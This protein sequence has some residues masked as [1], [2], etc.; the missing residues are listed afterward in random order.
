M[1]FTLLQSHLETI[2]STESTRN[3]AYVLKEPRKRVASRTGERR[4]AEIHDGEST[5]DGIVRN[6][7]R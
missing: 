4:K 7:T 1:I 3:S 6:M 5:P 2:I